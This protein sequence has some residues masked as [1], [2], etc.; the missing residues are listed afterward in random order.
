MNTTFPCSSNS[1]IEK[2]FQSEYTHAK[3]SEIQIEF[4][5]KISYGAFLK[6][7]EGT[8]AIYHVLEKIVIGDRA[9]E[10]MYEVV[11][12]M[13]LGINAYY[14]SLE[15]LFVGIPLVCLF[16]KELRKC[17]LSIF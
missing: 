10:A 14:L 15:P 9:K 2:Q 11:T 7:V 1:I 17:H 8:T 6:C 13:T 12:T 5:E 16:L 3:F 4:K